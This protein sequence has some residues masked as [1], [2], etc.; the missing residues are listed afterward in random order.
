ML[1]FQFAAAT[2][3]SVEIHLMI[4]DHREI[5]LI[6]IVAL[7][8]EVHHQHYDMHHIDDL[9]TKSLLMFRLKQNEKKNYLFV[10]G[11]K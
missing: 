1:L 11:K 3:I 8:C 9:L 5:H 10:N 4:V 6:W 7:V 2:K